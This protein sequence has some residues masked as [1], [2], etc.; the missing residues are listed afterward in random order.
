MS[1][2]KKKSEKMTL[3]QKVSDRVT[4]T[5]GS[6]KFI[7]IQSVIIVTWMTVN[8]MFNLWDSYPFIL[9]N[10][11]MS[12]QAAYAAPIIMMSQNR[13]AQ[14]DRKRAEDDYR[15]NLLAENEIE[16]IMDTLKQ[17]DKKL[18]KHEEIKSEIIEMKAEF[19][20]LQDILDAKKTD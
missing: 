11:A 20:L 4:T 10:L 12:F 18:V 13:E 1:Q 16:S 9:L 2:N 8:L 5:L 15:V 6:W 14:R 17:L 19:K 3:G 7:I